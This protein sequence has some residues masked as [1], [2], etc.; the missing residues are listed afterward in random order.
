M[1]GTSETKTARY[2]LA[3]AISARAEPP[4][5][6][7]NPPGPLPNDPAKIDNAILYPDFSF[8]TYD[9]S[10]LGTKHFTGQTAFPQW[11]KRVYA[12]L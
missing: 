5:M 4:E 9:K 11:Q 7:P 8:A 6:L 2:T 10:D 1:I 12:L 3:D